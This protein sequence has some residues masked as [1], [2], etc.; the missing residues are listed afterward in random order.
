MM[1]CSDSELLKIVKLKFQKGLE[2]FVTEQWGDYS[3]FRRN[4]PSS[5]DA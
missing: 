2:V 3:A 4:K 5:H 1:K